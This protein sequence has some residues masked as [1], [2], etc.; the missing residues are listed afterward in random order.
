MASAPIERTLWYETL[1]GRADINQ[2]QLRN[3]TRPIVVLGEAGMGKSHLLEWL[4]DVPGYALCTARQ[5]INRFDPRTLLGDSNVL[6]IDALDEVSA[7]KEGDAVDL[8][9]RKLGQLGYPRFVLS[10]RVADW[11]KAT[12]LQAIREQYGDEPLQFHLEPFS[13]ADAIAFLEPKFGAAS[14]TAVVSHFAQKGLRGLLGNP[15]TLEMIASIGPEK[16]PETRGELFSRAIEILWTEHNDSKAGQQ[17]AHQSA[18]DAAGAAFASLILTGH[19][20]IVRKARA[21][22]EEEELPIAEIRHLPG[23]DAIDAMLETRLFKAS[24]ADRFSYWHRRIGEHLGAQWLANCANTPRKRR[25]LLSLFHAN[26]LVPASLRGIHAWLA[27][28]PSLAIDVIAFD[29]M[30]VIEYGDADNLT[31]EEGLALLRALETLATDNPG[32]RDWGHY[33]MGGVART[34]LVSEIRRLIA[35]PET[36]FG[37]RILVLEAVKGSP[38][39]LILSGELRELV[40]DN[41]AIFAARSAAGQALVELHNQEDW[42]TIMSHLLRHGDE[43]SIR[44]AIELMD[45]IGYESFDD[46]LIVNL[47]LTHTQDDEH[48]S[49][50]LYRLEK[51]LPDSRLDELIDRWALAARSSGEPHQRPGDDAI[52]DFAYALIVRRVGAGS[53]DP[54]RLWNWLE[55]FD[56]SAGYHRETRKQLDELIARDADLRRAIQRHVLLDQAG[57]KNVWERAW[58]LGRRATTLAANHDDL[59][60]LLEALDPKDHQDERWREIVQLAIH[61]G[62]DGIEVRTAARPFTEHSRASLEWLEN[63]AIPRVHDWQLKQAEEQRKRQAQREMDRATHRKNLLPH[64]EAM[65]RG[66]YGLVINPAKAYLKLFFDIGDGVMA[67]ERVKQWLGEDLANAAHQGFEAF[68]TQAEPMPTADDIAS[69]F[70]EGKR[71]DAGFIIVA[72]L[73]ERLRLGKGFD[74]LSDERLMAGLFEVRHSNLDDHAKIDGLEESLQAALRSRLVWQETL[75]RYIEPQLSKQTEHVDG[76]YRLMRDDVDRGLAV[77][78]AIEWLERFPN[79]PN[80]P[81]VEMVKVALRSDR[82]H[83]LRRISSSRGELVSDEQRRLW[84][85]VGLI[86]D[87]EAASARL[88]AV[89]VDPELLWTLRHLIG[90]RYDDE[91]EIVLDAT[92]LEWIVSEFRTTWARVHRPSG[93]SVG[94]TNDWDASDFLNLLIQRLG[95][96]TSFEAVAA[97]RRLRDYPTDSY[98]DTLK[99]VWAEQARKQVEEGYSP[100]SIDVL[101]A[102][103]SDQAPA[104]AADLQA[105]MLEELEVVQA[106]I[107]SD[108]AESWRGFYDN[109]GPLGEDACRDHLLGLLRQGCQ[110]ITL[111]PERHVAGD[112]EVDIA[113]S[114]GALRMPIEIKGQWHPH[115]WRAAD[116]QLDFFYSRDWR[117][118]GRGI[119]VVLWFGAEVPHNKRLKSPGRNQQ[120]PTDPISLRDSLR[121]GSKA[122]N[123]G[124]VEIY[125]LDVTRP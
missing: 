32:F 31:A 56:A 68:L 10:C 58:Q 60:H 28:H 30:G 106:K 71:W 1:D 49:G 67:H 112:R 79:L 74:D 80:V 72:A 65:R 19:E 99:I 66:D 20:A 125:V 37:L 6:V 104:D 86:V 114:A 84:D 25:R 113:C 51:N 78:L 33:S 77:D 61:E 26:G 83:D 95:N 116:T 42:H 27:R 110:G 50:V 98:T 115:L 44:L 101:A 85:A 14:A 5:L 7:Q 73:A 107:R 94:D 9:L 89:E 111:D 21:K 121:A 91:T 36:P 75:R 117:A 81:E 53:I 62:K 2:A 96:D 119:Y 70:A 90:G 54:V 48:T 47:A 40:L 57:E 59:V 109:E 55:P 18:L 22:I 102:I 92:Q 88:A 24:S 82:Q 38:V 13:D 93:S 120:L 108:D 76:L 63:L 43:L 52:T 64:I 123:D 8:V 39:A 122:V 87:F 15:Q 34:E 3:Q 69:S 12:G 46:D 4:A 29:P 97:L 23:G 41:T 17:P 45:D 35:A 118:D 16:L 100:P 11:R 124:R 103:A 105:F